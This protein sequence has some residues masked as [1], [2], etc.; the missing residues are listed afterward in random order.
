MHDTKPR[1]NNLYEV[2]RGVCQMPSLR[3]KLL[4]QEKL[5]RPPHTLRMPLYRMQ[6]RP[7]SET[8][9]PKRFQKTAPIARRANYNSMTD[10][11][12]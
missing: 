7:S 6:M 10:S 9:P 4:E 1:N 12:P 2:K 8:N 11:S 5:T 3:P